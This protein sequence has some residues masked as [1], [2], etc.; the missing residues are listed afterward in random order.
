M[1]ESHYSDTEEGTE[2]QRDREMEEGRQAGR[3]ADSQ[4]FIFWSFC[5]E[6]NNQIPS[7]DS[8]VDGTLRGDPSSLK[9]LTLFF[10][11]F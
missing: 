3:Q 7:G 2:G 5:F 6:Y 4:L 11:V 10:F 8:E 1:S 9:G